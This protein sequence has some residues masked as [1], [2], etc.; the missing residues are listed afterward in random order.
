MVL[1]IRSLDIYIACRTACI[2]R[3]ARS[4]SA[5]SSGMETSS[6]QFRAE[7]SYCMMCISACWPV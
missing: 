6:H 2:F 3:I 7:L 1:Q 4:L 5:H